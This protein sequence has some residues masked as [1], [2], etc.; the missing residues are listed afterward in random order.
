MLT[1]YRRP[2]TASG[3]VDFPNVLAMVQ[4]RFWGVR[5]SIPT[6]GF[7]TARYGG[8]TSCVTVEPERSPEGGPTEL[9]ILDAGSGSRVLGL[10]LLR[11][12]RLPIRAHVLLTH[13]HW[14]HIQGFPFFA[15]AFI[16]GNEITV[17]GDAGSEDDLQ[18]TLAGQ[19]LH[20]YFPVSLEQLGATLR[21]AAVQ[22]GTH[23]VGSARVTVAS[24]HHPGKTVGYRVEV[25]GCSVAY[26]TDCEP[27]GSLPD[28]T[29][30]PGVLDL[31]R[32]VDVLIHD[33]QYTDAEY[34]SK[35]GWGHSPVGFV[36]DVALAAGA[37]RLVL[38]HHDPTRVDGQLDDLVETARVRAQG[39]ELVIEAAAEG[40]T[41]ELAG[42]AS[43]PA[44]DLVAAG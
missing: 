4:V 42:R 34:P 21:F 37:K 17:Y 5:G 19:M 32:D 43:V 13:T 9:F 14:D 44:I 1:G 10:N 6:P 38:F 2:A 35:V 20:R 40:T 3:G 36:V 16:P 39:T 25:G 24:L 7:D 33:A 27:S 11:E 26:V 15:P 18:T 41:I 22:P 31:A 28:L 30:D 8:N 23:E 29:I 12:K